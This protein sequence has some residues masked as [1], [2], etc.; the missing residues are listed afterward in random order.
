VR[1]KSNLQ[2]CHIGLSHTVLEARNILG[3]S[4]DKL[5]DEQIFDLVNEIQFLVDSWLEEFERKSFDGKT[6]NELIAL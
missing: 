3:D 5:T 1:Y 4:A 6:L 2:F